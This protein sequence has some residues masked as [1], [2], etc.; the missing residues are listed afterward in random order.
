MNDTEKRYL[1]RMG[2]IR[3]INSGNVR[4]IKN[5]WYMNGINLY[6][7]PPVNLMATVT[8]WGDDD[9]VIVIQGDS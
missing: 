7:P 9:N 8:Q 1:K 3:G 4:R 6:V 5:T 2:D